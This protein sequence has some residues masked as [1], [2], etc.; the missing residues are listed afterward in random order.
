MKA[1]DRDGLL[2]CELQAKTFEMSVDRT[3]MSSPIF[4]RRFMNSQAA[5]LMDEGSIL[6]TN[7]Q[8]ADLLDMLEEQYGASRYGSQKYTHNEMFWIGYV[9]RYY[10]Y[11]YEQSSASVYRIIKPKE[12][13]GVYLPYHTLD[14][15][16]AIERILE[17]RGIKNDSEGEL[18]R[19]YQI[20]K[21]VRMGSNKAV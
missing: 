15:S 8:P 9:Y 1:I 7:L 19:Q 20:F 3:E 21:K 10:A 12:L 2:L 14:P 16:Q 4:S 11:T 13:R 18:I 6:S 17:A 5:K